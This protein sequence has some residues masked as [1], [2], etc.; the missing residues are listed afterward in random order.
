M[1]EVVVIEYVLTEA[2]RYVSDLERLRSVKANAVQSLLQYFALEADSTK[3]MDELKAVPAYQIPKDT[4]VDS[5]FPHASKALLGYYVPI[6]K[7]ANDAV[8]LVKTEK[9]WAV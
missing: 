6:F 2:L 7:G 9:L 4:Q 5:Y 1:R 3:T 8:I